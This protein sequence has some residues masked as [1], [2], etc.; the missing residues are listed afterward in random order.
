VSENS[1][2]P[3]TRLCIWTSVTWATASHADGQPKFSKE[4]KKLARQFTN[5]P[6]RRSEI[7]AATQGRGSNLLLLLIGPP[8]LYPSPCRAFRRRLDLWFC[9]LAH[10]Q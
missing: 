6:A 1:A 10:G 4:L 7:L 5:C 2:G 8:L 3:L 9:S